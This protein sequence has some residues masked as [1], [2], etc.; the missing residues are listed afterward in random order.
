MLMV[1]VEPELEPPL[2][3]V[4]ALEPP[5]PP[6]ELLLELEP[7]HAATANAV[8]ATSSSAANGR[9]NLFKLILL[10]EVWSP[11]EGAYSQASTD[12]SHPAQYLTNPQHHAER[13]LNTTLRFG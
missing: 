3:V 11:S 7:P 8:I 13:I 10:Q 1:G 4:L 6:F 5:L 9:T 12:T 2:L